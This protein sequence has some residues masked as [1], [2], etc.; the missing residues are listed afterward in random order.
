MSNVRLDD[1]FSTIMS[2]AN[3]PSVNFF[4]K[5]VTPPGMEGGGANDTTTMR[6]T[7]LRTRAPKKL[8]TMSEM[9]AE[10]SYAAGVFDVTQV[11][12]MINVNQLITLTFP[13]GAQID[14]WGWLDEFK[15]GPHK[16]GEQPTATI[17]VICSNQN[18]SGVEVNI[19]YRA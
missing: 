6:N 13:D 16:D 12:A 9:S 19:V 3:N 8:K 7:T 10:V 15:P 17:K 4:E 18:T 1:G 2:F 14:F 5:T 11:W